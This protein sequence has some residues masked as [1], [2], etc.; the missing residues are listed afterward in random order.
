MWYAV[1]RRELHTG[2]WCRN[3]MERGFVNDLDMDG[4]IILKYI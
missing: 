4:W 3:L 1:G 2:F